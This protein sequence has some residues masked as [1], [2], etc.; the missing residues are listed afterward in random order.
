MSDKRLTLFIHEDN[1]E[2]LESSNDNMT[3]TIN[4]ALKLYGIISTLHKSG[5]KVYFQDHTDGKLE[6]VLLL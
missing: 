5:G 6:R 1:V 4:K 3:T 2:V